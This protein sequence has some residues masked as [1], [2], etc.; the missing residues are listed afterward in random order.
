[1]SKIRRL[2]DRL[3]LFMKTE[4]KCAVCLVAPLTD[5]ICD[6][7]SSLSSASQ[8][9]LGSIEGI[10]LDTASVVDMREKLDSLLQA[11]RQRGQRNPYAD[12]Q[13]QI[14]E[15]GV[16]EELLNSASNSLMNPSKDSPKKEKVDK[17]KAE[18]KILSDALTYGAEKTLELTQ[19]VTEQ[20]KQLEQL[21]DENRELKDQQR[22]TLEMQKKQRQRTKELEQRETVLELQACTTR[23]L[24][25]KYKLASNLTNEQEE[26]ITTLL[27]DLGD[28]EENAKER[29]A[30]LQST[31]TTS[32]VLVEELCPDERRDPNA[33][34]VHQALE[35]MI[36]AADRQRRTNEELRELLK[37]QKEAHGVIAHHPGEQ[38][39]D[40][41]PEQST[42]TSLT[43]EERQSQD[44]IRKTSTTNENQNE[45]IDFQPL[46]LTI[47]NLH[48]HDQQE[49]PTDMNKKQ[50]VT[51]SPT[52][53][54]KSSSD[55]SEHSWLD[56][57]YLQLDDEKLAKQPTL[58]LIEFIYD[59][60]SDLQNA[61]EQRDDDV[62]VL[63]DLVSD[64]QGE[65]QELKNEKLSMTQT[66]IDQEVIIEH[67]TCKPRIDDLES[68]LSKTTAELQ[69]LTQLNMKLNDEL[70]IT[71]GVLLTTNTKM[72]ALE[73]VKVKQER[74][75]S[76]MA[77]KSEERQ[78]LIVQLQEQATTH[79]E[80][81]RQ[82]EQH[83]I[84]L[85]DTQGIQLQQVADFKDV[86]NQKQEELKRQELQIANLTS[87]LWERD[88]ELA[89]MKENSSQ[90][91]S[92]GETPASIILERD[93]AKATIL[94]LKKQLKLSQ[95]QVSRNK[96]RIAELKDSR[97]TLRKEHRELKLLVIE[98]QKRQMAR[99]PPSDAVAKNVPQIST[100]S[101]ALTRAA[102]K[103]KT[104]RISTTQISPLKKLSHQANR[105]DSSQRLPPIIN[106]TTETID[107]D[108]LVFPDPAVL[109]DAEDSQ[110]TLNL[111]ED[112][113]IA[114][115]YMDEGGYQS[116]GIQV[117]RRDIPKYDG[118][119]HTKGNYSNSVSEFLE[120]MEELAIPNQ[121]TEAVKISMTFS[122]VEGRVKMHLRRWKI[123]CEQNQEDLT[124]EGLK[125]TLTHR[126]SNAPL[127]MQ[128][129]I[130]FMSLKQNGHSLHE[131]IL[132][133][134]EL[135]QLL[136]A[137]ST[138][139]LL[140]FQQGIYKDYQT[141]LL[142]QENPANTY[143]EAVQR[144]EVFE[145]TKTFSSVT[146]TS[147]KTDVKKDTRKLFSMLQQSH[148][149]THSK[150]VPKS[151]L[152]PAVC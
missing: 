130:K 128:K 95:T 144:C 51:S 57:D 26:R 139:L 43:P 97:E 135:G 104:A 143:S 2:N 12:I 137:D 112:N 68:K 10:N 21:Q 3:K 111:D 48:E 7:V 125:K 55:E 105:E 67:L 50:Q 102:A 34:I 148:P 24:A 109:G 83:A 89:T 107:P 100:L 106:L 20:E 77:T 145:A 138:S 38:S 96:A 63:N 80:R 134:E 103:V 118:M 92:G 44:L 45:D 33:Y 122:A 4:E 69:R 1:M 126:E 87:S 9:S 8:S 42:T 35:E 30:M 142:L 121:W 22:Q 59:L 140:T 84:R 71:R 86:I 70:N 79:L 47:E 88:R 133:L 98:L 113:I 93:H 60:R 41:D 99:H 32:K 74:D 108:E 16:E 39:P 116:T 27:D 114:P 56:K 115:E 72:L 132:E 15:L 73:A 65:L 120:T 136:S 76:A 147:K 124:W 46:N 82:L 29:E 146:T 28:Q 25:K 36:H 101:P 151:P 119:V 117:S 14:E 23:T 64:L 18:M 37:Q 62:G 17:K 53:S 58:V 66:S 5:C 6:T 90:I 52:L 40:K 54:R 152:H 129:R 149:T 94:E 110:D 141:F 75:L 81:Q 127:L 78:F 131:Y 49:L 13:E 11:K 123:D 61:Q 31:L 85:T 91:N 19:Q 150:Y